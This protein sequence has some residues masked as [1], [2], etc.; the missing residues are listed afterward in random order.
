MICKDYLLIHLLERK[1]DKRQQ[2]HPSEVWENL[3]L[4]ILWKTDLKQIEDIHMAFD[5]K[6]KE[7]QV[8]EPFVLWPW[9]SSSL[10]LNIFNK[11]LKNILS[12][13]PIQETINSDEER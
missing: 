10:L 4:L 9:L 11:E 7:K 6:W 13:L 3:S 5:P 12:R 8:S 1:G 2:Q